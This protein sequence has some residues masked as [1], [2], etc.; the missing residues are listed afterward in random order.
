[1]NKELQKV[2]DLTT[3]IE[4]PSAAR[5]DLLNG[6]NQAKKKL[7]DAITAKEDAETEN[8]LDRALDDER[9]AADKI[10]FFK[11]QLDKIDFT[12]RMDEAEYDKAV[13]TVENTV[14]KAA[15]AF[16]KAAMTAMEQL[17]NAREEYLQTA[18]DADDVLEMLDKASNVLQSRFRY[19]ELHRLGMDP[20]KI[21]DQWEWRNHATRYT[22][23]SGL[24][25]RIATG[26]ENG[27]EDYI[28]YAAWMAAGKVS[29][30]MNQDEY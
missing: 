3:K 13:E 27:P 10:A 2:Y 23:G 21:E 1:M 29:E 22:R 30:R 5:M 25:C 28:L 6:L 11:R 17:V 16:R 4:K 19:K 8:E 18:Q 7:E 12:P 9:R 15:D 20:V 26:N 24:A 14:E